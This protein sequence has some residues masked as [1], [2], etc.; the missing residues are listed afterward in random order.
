MIITIHL[1]LLPLFQLGCLFLTAEFLEFIAYFY[2]ICIC[3]CFLLDCGSSFHFPYCV[4][5]RAEVSTF[6]K[7]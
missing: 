3:K 6:N 1:Y 4:L 5:C 2:Q 7:V